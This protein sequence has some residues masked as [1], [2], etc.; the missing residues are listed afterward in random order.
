MRVDTLLSNIILV[1]FLVTI[2]MAVGSYVGYKL[3]EGRR[4]THEPERRPVESFFHRVSLAEYTAEDGA[5]MNL[6]SPG[7]RPDE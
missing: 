7:S 6:P 3:R 5:R 2:V 1:T 4:P